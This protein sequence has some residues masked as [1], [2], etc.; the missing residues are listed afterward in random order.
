MLEERPN[1]KITKLK[2][3]TLQYIPIP[4]ISDIY[5]RNRDSAFEKNNKNF[6]NEQDQT[7]SYISDISDSKEKLVSVSSPPLRMTNEQYDSWFRNQEN[8]NSN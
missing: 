1:I 4:D 2:P 8:D 7:R 6:E 3:K 5:D